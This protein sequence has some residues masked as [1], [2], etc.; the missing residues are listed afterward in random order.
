MLN[1]DIKQNNLTRKSLRPAKRLGRGL[2]SGKGNTSG[3]GTK[4]Q[5]SRSGYNIPRRFEGG[6]TPWIQRL[7]K[8]KGFRSRK[9]KPITLS[10]KLIEL[11]FKEDDEINQK[12]LFEKGLI[13]AKTQPV[14][15]LGKLTKKFKFRNVILSKKILEDLKKLEVK[16]VGKPAVKSIAKPTKTK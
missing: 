9:V 11:K 14:K 6:Q 16:P 1:K 10:I 13:K 3:R 12:T 8:K 7:S 15:I 4:G 5:K 2:A